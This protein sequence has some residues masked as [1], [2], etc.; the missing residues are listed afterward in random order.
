MQHVDVYVKCSYWVKIS[1]I[2]TV[3][4]QLIDELSMRRRPE[5]LVIGKRKTGHSQT[6]VLMP[7][8]S[9]QHKLTDDEDTQDGHHPTE[10]VG[11]S[12]IVLG[13]CFPS[14]PAFA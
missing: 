13:C 12:M 8:E 1:M 14:N 11:H 10:T 4:V 9:A 7:H 5:V 2:H 3:H 6:C